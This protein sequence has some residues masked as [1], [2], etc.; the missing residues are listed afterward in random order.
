M[1]N[2]FDEPITGYKQYRGSFNGAQIEQG[3]FS[4]TTTGLTVDV[5]TY[6]TKIL[7]GVVTAQSTASNEMFYCGLTVTN[8]VVEVGRALPTLN[9][10]FHFPIPADRIA[11]ND[12]SSTPLF[13]AQAEIALSQVEFYK[14]TGYGGGTATF[15]L[16]D[17]SDA[18]EFITSAN[19]AINETG[20]TTDTFTTLEEN[21]ADG[22]V[23]HAQTLGGTTSGPG[24]MV[25]S[26]KGTVVTAATSG[27]TFNYTFMGYH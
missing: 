21:V 22:D 10:E 9:R 13:V 3:E 24:D 18:D 2:Y 5:P 15:N 17:A 11:S 14:G 23:V 25:I 20:G 26:M 8:G 16:G 19:G 12:L 7:S 1:P 27:L 6:F 4:F